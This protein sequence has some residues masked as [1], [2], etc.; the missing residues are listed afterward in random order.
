ME[1]EPK[2]RFHC[3]RYRNH[4]HNCDRPT[5]GITMSGKQVIRGWEWDSQIEI[6]K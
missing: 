2:S 4:T 1:T 3:G 5:K 6:S